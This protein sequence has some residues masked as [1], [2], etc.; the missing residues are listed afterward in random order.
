METHR[1][2]LYVNADKGNSYYNVTYFQS[3]GVEQIPKEIKTSLGNKTIKTII[4]RI[5]VS[6]LHWIY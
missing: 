1:I 5:Q 2:A 3:V 4:H 6:Y